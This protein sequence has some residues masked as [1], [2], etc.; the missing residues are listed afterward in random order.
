VASISL[1]SYSYAAFAAASLASS[2][3]IDATRDSLSS[4]IFS[5]TLANN[6]GL[7]VEATSMKAAIGLAFPILANSTKA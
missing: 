3:A 6:S 2:S 7:R 4:F 1:T 5:I